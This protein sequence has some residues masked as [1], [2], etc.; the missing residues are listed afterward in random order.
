MC[1]N[2]AVNDVVEDSSVLT[3]SFETWRLGLSLNDTENSPAVG[4]NGEG[5]L[6]LD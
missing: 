4:A 1:R 6:A 3:R 2:R 5:V